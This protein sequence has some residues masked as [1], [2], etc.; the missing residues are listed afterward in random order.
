MI[1]MKSSIFKMTRRTIRSFFGRYMALLLI[2]M[3][4]VGFF[5][6]LKVTK[7]AMASTCE[8]YLNEQHFS[9][10]RLISTLGFTEADVEKL[11]EISDIEEA[12]GTKSIDVMMEYETSEMPFRLYAIP[13]KVN[14]PL[15]S[16]GR[17]PETE[18]ECLA[19]D[20]WF[21]NSDIG[22]TIRVAVEN[23]ETV[24]EQLSGTEFTI[25][26]LANSPAYLD[27]DRGS[28][29]IGNGAIK[30][31][32]YLP[33]ECFTSEVYTEVNLTLRET[34]KIY[35][36]EYD[37][38]ID[39]HI[40]EITDICT[41]L[42]DQRY[43]NLLDENDLTEELAAMLGVTQSE[44]AEQFGI[45]EPDVYVLTRKENTGYN[46]FKNDTSIVS[47]IANIL[48]VF[49]ILI[50]ML[51]CIT[52]MTRM[53][54]EERTQIGVLKAMGYGNKAVI[55]K[56][57][58]YAGSATLIGWT[59]GFFV[60]TWGLPKIFWLAYSALYDFA[61]ISFLFSPSLAFI[62]LAVS[63]SSILGSTYLS[64]RKELRRMPA[65]LIRPRT[66]KSGKR[67]LL[68]HIPLL[69]SHLSFLQKITLR[70]MFRY[71]QRLIMMLVGISCCA[72]LVVTAF[73]VRDSMIHV[74]S[75]QYEN[76]Q[77][78]D[79]EAF[80]KEGTG[81]DIFSQID[82]IDGIGTYLA[83]AK[84]YVDLQT[85]NNSMD[86]VTMISFEDES[87]IKDF[88][89]FHVGEKDILLPEYGEVIINTKIADKLELSV[90]D[91]FQIQNADMQ[92]LTVTVSG[93]FDN[94]VLNYV[95]VSAD[96]YADIFDFW[97]SN[98]V[99]LSA[100]GD[101][102]EIAEQI[103]EIPDI[104]SVAKLSSTQNSIDNALS[105]INYI[106][107]MVVL[108]AGALAFI[109]IFNLTNINLAERSREVATVEVLGFYPKE[110]ESYVLRENLVLSVIASVIGLPLGTLFH[111]AVMH[112]IMIDI[113]T[114]DIHIKSVSYALAFICTVFFALIV[115]LFMK[116]QIGKIHM[117]ESLKAV[118]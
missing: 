84:Q 65:K 76:V 66:A 38:L 20:E 77:L 94:F 96:T 34:A 3:L 108:F 116:R 43:E 18:Y 70:N 72:G 57:L 69:W 23:E 103:V 114:F 7:D 44:L 60:G 87:N 98:T 15:L 12:E 48:P 100:N 101:L 97:E 59:V 50:A 4:S 28:T 64:C 58:L 80:Y 63:L 25:V 89:D 118:E 24:S 53:V 37:D 32:F 83:G 117:A 79:L 41:D 52:T 17:M 45:M 56:Y 106:I 46:S 91:V 19:D 2:V 112:M 99:M 115:N 51:V 93:I 16:A 6:G 13:E 104:A 88:W 10:Y 42:A 8:K 111:R 86:S 49:F 29:N 85:D 30:A 22:V 75:L 78:Y 81:E 14:V 90:G 26:G 1:D 31:F 27:G 5:A 61:P 113:I 33:S 82:D 74:A 95:I 110:T 71:K 39:A 109:V 68:E 62:T 35:S 67:I 73:G 36:D 55:G 107:W 102:E 21:D 11:N 47:G 92:T 105:C 9:D 54:D 40:D